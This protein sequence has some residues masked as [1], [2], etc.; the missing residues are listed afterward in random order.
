M[1]STRWRPVCRIWP[2]VPFY[3]GQPSAADAAKIKSPMLLHYAALD[4]RTNDGWPA[5][6]A[7]LKTNG[8]KY[9]MFMYAGANHGFH[10]DTTPRYDEAAAKLAWSRTTA[11]L[12][13]NLKPEGARVRRRV[14]RAGIRRVWSVVPVRSTSDTR[15]GTC[16]WDAVE[17]G[18]PAPART[19]RRSPGFRAPCRARDRGLRIAA[20][21]PVGY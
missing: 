15:A 12:K 2:L 19:G 10:N 5:F 11:F 18:R 1:W 4:E 17:S 21:R 3:G 14:P 16:R 7:V 6:E 8:V 20:A 9:Q 13:E